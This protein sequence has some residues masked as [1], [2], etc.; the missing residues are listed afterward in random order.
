VLDR[1]VEDRVKSE[2]VLQTA[3]EE[4]MPSVEYNEGRLSGLVTLCLGTAFW[5]TLLKES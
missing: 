3:K 1:D 2:E 4:R 5:N